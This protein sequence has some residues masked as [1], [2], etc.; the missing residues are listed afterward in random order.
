MITQTDALAAAIERA[1]RS[2]T[3]TLEQGRVATYIPELSKASPSRLGVVVITH[4]GNE[5]TCGDVGAPFTLQSVSK[6]ISLTVALARFGPDAVFERVGMEPTGE[7]FNSLINVEEAESKPLNPMINSGAIAVCSLLV[8]RLGK[9]AA[10]ESVSGLT[11]ALCSPE[12]VTLSESVYMSE[13]QTAHRNRALA[14]LLRELGIVKGS[15]DEAIDMYLRQCSL[16]V[17]CRGLAMMAL[18]YADP[19]SIAVTLGVPVQVIRTVNT[20]LVTCGMYNA[21]GEFAIKAGIP[22]KSGVSGA[23]MA[24][25]PGHMGIGLIG[26]SLDKRGNSVGGVHF[27]HR[28]SEE[29]GL[30]IFVARQDHHARLEEVTSP[31]K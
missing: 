25:V 6:V 17:S 15:P 4:D 14:Y 31:M 9:E 10:W 13:R 3:S 11:A 19:A 16:E 20:F 26:P 30:S 29:L 1:H 27:L 22:A 12:R 24:L 7:P 2:A 28:L 5:Y 8:E 23:I 21:S 18:R